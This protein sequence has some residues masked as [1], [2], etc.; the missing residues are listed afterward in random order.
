MPLAG[1]DTDKERI[2]TWN[3]SNAI[4]ANKVVTK[5][6]IIRKGL[7]EEEL[8]GYNPPFLDGI[9][10]RAPYLHN[11]SVPTLR[12]LL[13]PAENRPK[14]FWRGYDLY[15]QKNVGFVTQ[16]ADAER[17]GTRHDT[18]QRANSNRGHEFGTTLPASE[19]EALLEYLKT[20]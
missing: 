6:G 2:G 17:I 20:L 12:D 15:D 9:W 13:E 18:T 1:I 10:A 14:L 3:K 19:K 4:E 11:G 5:M 16:G 8:V 7:V